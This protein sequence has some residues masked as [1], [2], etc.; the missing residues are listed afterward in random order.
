MRIQETKIYTFNELSDESKEKALDN[1]RDTNVFYGGE[2]YDGVIYTCKDVAKAL[3]V[4]TDAIHFSGFSSQGVG[5]CFTGTYEYR[6]GWRAELKAYA[7]INKDLLEIGN[8]LQEAQ[9]KAFYSIV[10]RIAHR[11]YY[12]HSGCMIIDSDTGAGT[13]DSDGIRDALRLLADWMYSSLEAEYDYLTSDEAVRE[14]ILAN[15]YEFT[16]NGISTPATP[17]TPSNIK[18]QGCQVDD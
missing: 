17:A 4:S 15:E 13:F 12:S 16:E 11:G 7:P 5:A 18:N 6:K 3:G 1:C 10:A 9:R 14:S 2:W 8:A